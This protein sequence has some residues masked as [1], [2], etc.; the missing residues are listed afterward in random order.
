MWLLEANL[1]DPVS[2]S[3]DAKIASLG[4]LPH[5]DQDLKPGGVAFRGKAASCHHAAER[6]EPSVGNW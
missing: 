4:D 1:V 3:V 5:A 6:G 2:G